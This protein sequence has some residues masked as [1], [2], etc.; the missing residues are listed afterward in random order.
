[1][2]LAC[3]GR[4]SDAHLPPTAPH[5]IT[6]RVSRCA[7]AARRVPTRVTDVAAFDLDGTLTE[8]GS[9]FAFLSAVVG[10]GPV[11][12]ASSALAVPLARAALAGGTVAD[13]T[14][15][16]LFVRVLAGVPLAD[17]EA[18]A[19]E[20]GQ[21]HVEAE[22]RSDV[23]ARLEQHRRRGDR[24]VLVS[25]SPALYV[26]VIAGLLGADHAIAT[27]LDHRQGALTGRYLGKN[28]RGEEKIRR[29]RAW[30]A[31]ET[32]DT[33]R[34]WAYGN[35]RGDLRMLSA[36]DYGVSVAKLGPLSRLRHFPNLQATEATLTKELP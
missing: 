29:L 15:E 13:D 11:L 35:S 20:F 10:R 30:I 28:C 23:V 17:A 7:L 4:G 27:E 6:N 12:A 34:L 22:L 32:D 8:G 3:W 5:A 31:A 24:I 2:E 26:R 18:K 19:A 25:A 14:K 36:A 16:R 33:G 21:H 1:M 9:V